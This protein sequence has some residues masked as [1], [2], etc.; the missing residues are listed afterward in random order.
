MSDNLLDGARTGV[1]GVFNDTADLPNV[2]GS[3]TQSRFLKPSHLAIGVFSGTA[4]IK[5]CTTATQGAA[6]WADVAYAGASIT[7]NLTLSGT[8]QAEQLTSTDDLTVTDAITAASL[9]ATG[10]V[11]AEHLYTTDDLV[12]DGLATVGETLG[13]TGATTLTGGLVGT[14]EQRIAVIDGPIVA[15]TGTDVTYAAAGDEYLT[16]LVIRRNV[17]LTGAALLNGPTVATDSVIYALWDSSGSLV[18]NTALA[19]TTTSGADAWQQIA[20]TSAYAAVP[21][22]YFLGVQANGTTDDFHAIAAG[23]TKATQT[24]TTDRGSFGTISDLAAVPT[25]FAADVGPIMYVYE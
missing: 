18:A 6:V 4:S 22:R 21:G 24:N 15:T 7:G 10:T 1:W 20:F 3:A 11:Q 14:E 8:L 9:T 17:T 23:G 12:V 16:E 13:V 25:A 2:A 19:G 5:I